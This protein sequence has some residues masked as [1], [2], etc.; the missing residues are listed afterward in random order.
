MTCSRA[1]MDELI[2]GLFGLARNYYDR[3]LTV[4]QNVARI[5]IKVGDNSSRAQHG[6][7]YFTPVDIYEH[8]VA[9]GWIRYDPTFAIW[10]YS[11]IFW[12]LFRMMYCSCMCRF[13]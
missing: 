2:V 1:C 3:P 8:N 13:C 9:F 7:R 4:T 6:L 10:P 5:P 12:L 11:K